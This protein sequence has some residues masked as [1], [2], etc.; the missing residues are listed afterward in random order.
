VAL[1]IWVDIA[2]APPFW[3]HVLLWTPLTIGSVLGG[4]RLAKALLLTNEY[5]HSAGEGRVD[6]R[7]QS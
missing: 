3:L 5:R 4:L 7:D 1:A 6:G 2:F